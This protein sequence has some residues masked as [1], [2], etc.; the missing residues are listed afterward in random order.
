MDF[1][2]ADDL[3][4][5]TGRKFF[6]LN[7]HRENL[8]QFLFDGTVL[9]TTQRLAQVRMSTLFSNPQGQMYSFAAF[10]TSYMI[11]FIGKHTILVLL[12]ATTLNVAVN[13]ANKALLTIMMSNNVNE[14]YHLIFSGT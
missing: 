2:A 13:S 9:F 14:I 7:Q 1:K 12:Q 4:R 5:Q 3:N 10:P 11:Y 6:L 8:P